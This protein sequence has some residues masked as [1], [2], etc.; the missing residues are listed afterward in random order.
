VRECFDRSYIGVQ[1]DRTVCFIHTETISRGLQ[2]LI[3]RKKKIIKI[4]TRME[5]E[6][7]IVGMLE[8][9]GHGWSIDNLIS[10]LEKGN[11]EIEISRELHEP[12]SQMVHEVRCNTK[13]KTV[14]KK[15]QPAAVPFPLDAADLLRR[16]Q[17]EPRLRK[18]EDNRPYFY[19]GDIG[20]ANNR[21]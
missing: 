1:K 2:K 5:E 19:Q 12:L 14:D 11:W 7:D 10:A 18:V 15:V 6:E 9:S 21:R 17:G 13:Y 3:Q 4:A 8:D 20:A 16:T